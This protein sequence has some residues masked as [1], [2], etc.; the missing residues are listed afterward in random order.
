[1]QTVGENGL[2]MCKPTLVWN[3]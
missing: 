1:M 2:W 3:N